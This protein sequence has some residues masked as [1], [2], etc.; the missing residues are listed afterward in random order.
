[1]HSKWKWSRFRKKFASPSWAL[2]NLNV[3]MLKR[4]CVCAYPRRVKV[5]RDKNSSA[6]PVCQDGR[7]RPLRR[8]R[9]GRLGQRLRPRLRGF[10]GLGGGSAFGL[11]L[12]RSRRSLGGAVSCGW[13][14][15]FE[16]AKQCA[17]RFWLC[18]LSVSNWDKHQI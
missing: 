4:T 12:R 9:P 5:Q 11:A 8:L 2:A 6:G 1:M 10:P 3:G 15:G 17:F 14:H 7:H 13:G 18:S 16:G